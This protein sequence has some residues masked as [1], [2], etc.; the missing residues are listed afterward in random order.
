VRG[1]GMT[2][3]EGLFMSP[4]VPLGER[5]VIGPAVPTRIDRM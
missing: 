2:K 5:K 4:I 3:N 1:I